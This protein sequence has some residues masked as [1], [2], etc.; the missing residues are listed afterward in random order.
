MSLRGDDKEFS[1]HSAPDG[2]FVGAILAGDAGEAVEVW[3]WLSAPLD[4]AGRPDV[5]AF[6]GEEF[7]AQEICR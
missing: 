2:A 4:R 7:F 5:S 6:G 1:I 3:E